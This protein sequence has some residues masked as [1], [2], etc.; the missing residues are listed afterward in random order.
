MQR[1][2]ERDHLVEGSECTRDLRGKAAIH[3]LALLCGSVCPIAFLWCSSSSRGG[4]GGG[5]GGECFLLIGLVW[6]LGSLRWRVWWHAVSHTRCVVRISIFSL[7]K[8]KSKVLVRTGVVPCLG[9]SRPSSRSYLGETMPTLSF[10]VQGSLASFSFIRK[11]EK[12][13]VCLTCA[14]L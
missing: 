9:G 5:G 6:R 4:G 3:L 10:S 12:K 11:I 13:N 14:S 2:G 7:S 8:T 1:L